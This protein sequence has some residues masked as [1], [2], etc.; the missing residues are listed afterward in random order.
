[1]LGKELLTIKMLS[2][3]GVEEQ[4]RNTKGAELGHVSLV[5]GKIGDSTGD[6]KV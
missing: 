6:T 1:M 4:S 3:S 2:G 5:V